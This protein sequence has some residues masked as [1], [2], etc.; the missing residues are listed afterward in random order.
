VLLH[1]GRVIAAGPTETMLEGSLIRTLYGVDVDIMA[2]PRT[3]Q[4]TV[5]PIGRA[6]GTLRG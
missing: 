2:N 3:G 1:Q 5:I 6:Q 4:L